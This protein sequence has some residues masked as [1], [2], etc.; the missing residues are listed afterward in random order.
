MTS[1]TTSAT[2][3]LGLALSGG[4]TRAIGFHLGVLQT[5]ARRQQ[6]EQITRISTV[7][8]GSL[9]VAAIF[10][11]NRHK[12]PSSVQY[13][14]ETLPA[15]KELLTTVDLFSLPSVMKDW[16]RLY[17]LP[18]ARSRIV[19]HNLA[20][21]WGARGNLAD[22]PETPV[23]QI[24]T[25]CIETGKNWRFSRFEMGDW[26]FGR[27]YSPDVSIAAAAAASAAVPYALG[28]VPF[29]LPAEGWFETD[30][31][32]SKPLGRK[33]P[34]LQTVRLWDGGAYENL[35]L[36]PLYK[37]GRGLIDCDEL[38][39]SDA[40]GHLPTIGST[41]S[42]LGILRGNLSSPRLFDI[43]ADQ[44]RGLRSRMF[45]DA[46]LSGK[47]KGKLFRLGR[48]VRDI[49]LA[50]KISRPPAA[51]SPMQTDAYVSELHK[52]PTNLGRL[53]SEVVDDLIRHGAECSEAT[54]STY[55]ELHAVKL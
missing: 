25:T 21:K 28:A 24:N 46:V 39:V 12:W 5:L 1:L 10:S 54:L 40:S 4:G 33:V 16:R 27:H 23:W 49:E 15:I 43:A 17:L 31:A 29:K 6:L 20:E 48:S 47:I 53:S 34:S 14:E 9:L 26:V 8:G 45:M 35:G 37:P 2:P 13:L 30:P 7:S 19:A 42:R 36:E 3:R 18:F 51:Y 55:S 11:T 22:L 44:I 32:T 50:A 52:Y 41:Q 38:Y